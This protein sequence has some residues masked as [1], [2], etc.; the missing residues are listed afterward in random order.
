M[1]FTLSASTLHEELVSDAIYFDTERAVAAT[2][3]SRR[4]VFTVVMRCALRASRANLP[5]GPRGPR[6]H[7]FGHLAISAEK[8]AA[9]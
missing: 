5:A 1:M 2:A 6:T 9:T 4:H 3:A 8:A 7:V